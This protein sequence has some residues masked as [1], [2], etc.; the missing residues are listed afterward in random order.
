MK[1]IQLIDAK[2]PGGIETHVF[3]LAEELQAKRHT[4]TIIF[5]CDYPG[6]PLY[7]ICQSRGIPYETCHSWRELVSRLKELKPDIINTHGYKANI[8]GRLIGLT[9]KTKVVSTYH[10][11]E[12]PVGRLI[13][14]NF[15]DRWSSFL[16]HNIAVNAVIGAR[17]PT[18]VQIIPNFVDIPDQPAHIKSSGPYKIYF[19]GRF[20][21][22]KG[23]M[24]FCR[25]STICP[26][27]FNW[28]MVGGGILLA[29]C[30]KQYGNAI[31]FHGVVTD[32]NTIWPDVDLLCI[33]SV[34]EGLPLVLLE[35]M[36]RGIPVISF[37]V[38]SVRDV[39]TDS[40]YI[41]QKANIELMS[42]CLVSH[43]NKPA[44]VR[45]AMAKTARKQV[46]DNFSSKAVLPGITAFYQS[47]RNDLS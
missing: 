41:I 7:K 36:S 22:E 29:S 9:I 31:Q 34:Y 24:D 4:C 37:D 39:M 19:I 1:I 43:F 28:H 13:L 44:E 26:P 12:K 14:Y 27:D 32:M 45:E 5:I 10:S 3:N 8:L 17:L 42:A 11:G 6:N 40:D 16:S 15:L 38:G 47:V 46:L 23:P 25:L 20:S 30:Q 35:A 2:T 33:T 21:P 18:R